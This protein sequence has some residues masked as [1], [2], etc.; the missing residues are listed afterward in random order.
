MVSPLEHLGDKGKHDT[1]NVTCRRDVSQGNIPSPEGN[2]HQVD[3]GITEEAVCHPVVQLLAV[4][5]FPAKLLFCLTEVFCL[6]HGALQFTP[7]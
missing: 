6:G 1:G 7:L 2:G 3:K 4:H 5:V